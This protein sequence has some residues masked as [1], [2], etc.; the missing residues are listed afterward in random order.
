MKE[1]RKKREKVLPE[2][3]YLYALNKKATK[4]KKK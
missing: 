2:L 4:G 1:K 3:E